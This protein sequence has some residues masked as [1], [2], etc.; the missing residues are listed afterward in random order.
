[1]Q[2][3]KAQLLFIFAQAVVILFF[4]LFTVYGEGTSPETPSGNEAGIKKNISDIYPLF[5][6]V[7]IMIFVGFG[8]LLVFLKSHKLSTVGFN[9]LIACWAL[10]IAILWNHFWQQV[11]LH[12]DSEEIGFEK[13]DLNIRTIL[14]GDYGAA[15]VLITFGALLGKVS[16]LQLFVIA[17]FEIFFYAINKSIIEEVFKA[18]DDGGSMIIH[19]FGAYFGIACQFF[20]HRKAA[21]KNE[22]KLDCGNYVS[23]VISMIGTLFL[24]VYWPSFNAATLSGA[25][26]QRAIINTYLSLATSVVIAIFWSKIIFG[27]LKLEVIL[28]ASLAGGVAMGCNANIIVMPFGSMLVGLVSGTIASLGY[29]YLQPWLKKKELIHD[30]CGVQ[31]LFGLPGIVGGLTSAIVASRSRDN[32][33]WNYGAAFSIDNENLRTASEQAGY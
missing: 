5:Q 17:T 22:K 8:F 11:M 2:L 29:G 20:F 6:D 26:Q 14:N 10:Q 31:F 30:T 27:K 23:D 12:Y 19:I 18:T 24:F 16:Y 9:F 32:F 13:L 7:H 28:N 15:A 3:G 21:C 4:G 33:G 1:M 25:H